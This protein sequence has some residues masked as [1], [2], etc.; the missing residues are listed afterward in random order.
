MARGEIFKLELY[1]RHDI[2]ADVLKQSPKKENW[3]MAVV[4]ERLVIVIQTHEPTEDG[5]PEPRTDQIIS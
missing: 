4:L 2:V 1:E 5:Q 3:D